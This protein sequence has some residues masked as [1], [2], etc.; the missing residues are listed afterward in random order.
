MQAE[1]YSLSECPDKNGHYAVIAE[2][3]GKSA[4][5]VAV[6]ATY[7]EARLWLAEVQQVSSIPSDGYGIC[8]GCGAYIPEG[9]TDCGACPIEEGE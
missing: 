3:P 8:E 9:G 2:A 6:C 5:L 1:T 4:R 7:K